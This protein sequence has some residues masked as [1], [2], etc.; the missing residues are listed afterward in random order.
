ML[1][2]ARLRDKRLH[3]AE[4]PI[5]RRETTMIVARGY[6]QDTRDRVDGL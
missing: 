2:S 4:R 1:A 6:G 3:P 5:G